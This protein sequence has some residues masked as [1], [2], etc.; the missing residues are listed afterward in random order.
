[1]EDSIIDLIVYP[2]GRCVPRAETEGVVD[3]PREKEATATTT[4]R[5]PQRERADDRQGQAQDKLKG[6]RH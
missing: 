4:H 5:R 6:H 3:G 1:V 2:S